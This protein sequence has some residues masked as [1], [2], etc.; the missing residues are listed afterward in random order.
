MNDMFRMYG[1]DPAQLPTEETLV[2]N[3]ENKLVQYL[4]KAENQEDEKESARLIAQQLYELALMAHKPLSA[5]EST[6]FASRSL[7]IMELLINK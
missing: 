5:E 3:S 7:K 2:L 6:A 4:E 1:M